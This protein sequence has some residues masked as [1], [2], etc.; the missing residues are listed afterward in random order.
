MKPFQPRLIDPIS[1]SLPL[2]SNLELPRLAF[3]WHEWIALIATLIVNI[4]MILAGADFA[5]SGIPIH[6]PHSLGSSGQTS[7]KIFVF[8]LYIA[9]ISLLCLI[10]WRSCLDQARRLWQDPWVR[11]T[12]LILILGMARAALDLSQNPLL[13]IRN[14]AF[15]WYLSVPLLL[16][17]LNISVARLDLLSKL[18]AALVFYLFLV[19]VGMSIQHRNTF[20]NWQPYL[21]LYLIFAFG[22][23]TVYRWWGILMLFLIGFPL[24][25]CLL[26]K[27]QR[28]FLIGMAITMVLVF[29][30]FA[31]LRK[32]ILR[33][34]AIFLFAFM[35]GGAFWLFHA[36]SSRWNLGFSH[37]FDNLSPLTKSQEDDNG[38]E[39][40]RGSMWKDALG[41]FRE[42]P[43]VGIGFQKQVVTRVFLGGTKYLENTG[44]FEKKGTPPIAGPHNSYL[45]ALARLGILGSLFFVL[46][47]AMARRLWKKGVY[48]TFFILLAQIVYAFFNV[49]L[50]GPSRSSMLLMTLASAFLVRLQ[51]SDKP[52]P[53]AH[54]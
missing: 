2:H 35:A 45:N 52:H 46:H 28:T 50:E 47:I 44:D 29:G 38:L 48:A 33:R 20:L 37:S 31:N 21:G 49:G 14:S 24:G 42:Q 18:M 30:S 11:V 27:F 26:E 10:R 32:I 17:L 5:K 16:A 39:I 4:G 53:K 40:F 3:M 19:S 12:L 43:L 15:V 54:A 34:L 23:A 8:E 6:L 13:G 22:L 25:F 41:L 9:I 7:Q 1:A 36:H 51:L